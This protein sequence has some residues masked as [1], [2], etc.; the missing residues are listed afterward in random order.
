MAKISDRI[1]LNPATI[2]FRID[3]NLAKLAQPNADV[4]LILSNDERRPDF[5]TL[6]KLNS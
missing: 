5:T 4:S 2:S 1:D 6:D 3:F